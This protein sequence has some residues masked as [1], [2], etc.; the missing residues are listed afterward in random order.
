MQH[1]IIRDPE[2]NGWEYGMLRSFERAVSDVTGA[3]ICEIPAYTI[4]KNHIHHF[5]Q[6]MNKAKFRRYFPKQP[7]SIPGDICWYILMGPENYRLDLYNGWDKNV[8]T[9]ILY[10]YDTF[11][12]QYPLIKKTL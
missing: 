2:L 4:L 11:P 6:G 9:K 5:G 12:S 3:A 8:K 1:T 7:L 10:L